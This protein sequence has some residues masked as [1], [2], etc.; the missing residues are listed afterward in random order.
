[1]PTFSFANS[2]ATT[3]NSPSEI[4]SKPILIKR[5]FIDWLKELPIKKITPLTI[6]SMGI[7]GDFSARLGRSSIVPS[8]APNGL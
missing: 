7:I 3:V 1:M 5:N 4:A 8:I 6:S 2:L